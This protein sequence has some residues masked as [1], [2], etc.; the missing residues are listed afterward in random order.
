MPQILLFPTVIYQHDFSEDPEFKLLSDMVDRAETKPH[1]LVGWAESSYAAGDRKFLDNPLLRGIRGRI[2]QC[3]NQ[4]TQDLGLEPVGITNSWFNKMSK[5]QRVERHRHEC[6]V[7]SGALYIH[8]DPGSVPL[9]LFNNLN[10]L[11]ML[12]RIE[13][14]NFLNQTHHEVPCVT[15]SLVIFPSWLEHDTLTN[16]TDSRITMSFNSAYYSKNNI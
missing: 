6:S 16:E 15:G 7:V 4:Y 13:Q 8:A 9:R 10:S 14:D 1:G 12:E 11:R 2:Q 5:G 3:V